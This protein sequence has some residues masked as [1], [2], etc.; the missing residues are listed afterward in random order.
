MNK[1]TQLFVLLSFFALI[2]C[3]DKAL[4]KLNKNYMIDNNREVQVKFALKQNNLE[5]FSNLVEDIATP[6]S[7]M[8]GKYLSHDEIAR[9]IAPSEGKVDSFISWLKM[10]GISDIKTVKTR[11][12]IVVKMTIQQIK[13]I[14]NV[15]LQSF[16]NKFNNKMIHRTLES[17]VVDRLPAEFRSMIDLIHGIND[18]P[19]LKN[20]HLKKLKEKQINDN[21]FLDKYMKNKEN[22]NPYFV[23]ARGNTDS[24]ITVNWALSCSPNCSGYVLAEFSLTSSI[25]ATTS[26]IKYQEI[27]PNCMLGRCKTVIT[28]VDYYIPYNISMRVTSNS[29]VSP[30]IFYDYVVVST[31]AIIPNDLYDLYN[32]PRSIRITNPNIT[33]CVVEFEQQYYSPSDLTL[34]ANQMGVAPVPPITVIGP[35]DLSNP[36]VEANLDI[37]WILATGAGSPTTFWSI[38]ANSTIEIDNILEWEY[39]IGNMTNPPLVNSLSYGMTEKNVDTYLG[40]GYLNRSNVEFQKLASMGLTV[41]IA[42]GDTGANDLGPPPMSYG[43]NCFPSN[44]DWPSDSPYVTAVGSTFITPFSTELCYL[45]KEHGGIDCIAEPLGEVTTSVDAG[46]TWTTGGGFSNMTSM[47]SYQTKVVNSYLSQKTSPLP[48]STYFNKNGRAYPDVVAVGHNLETA[49]KGDFIPVDGTSASAPIFAGI[50]TLLN[51]ERAN[52][53]MPPMGW[54]NPMFYQLYEENPS[55]FQDVTVGKNRCGSVGYDPVCCDDGFECSPG[56]DTVSGMGSVNYEELR[57]AVVQQGHP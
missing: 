42:D 23:S 52:H 36:G 45:D 14:F 30:V 29:T 55:L 53:G 28:N 27:N 37:Q 56:F 8:Y 7:G 20:G 12:L 9:I 50:V 21:I 10:N 24:S 40:Q 25:D 31:P 39:A 48:P 38:Y 13:E 19:P 18:F 6:G 17:N 5:Y 41:I 57:H 35:N 11:D 51:N 1:F 43:P 26:D 46:I 44:P 47:P 22:N 15:E 34:F 33:Q 16:K 2:S 4:W 49:F 3:Y 54:I 32:I